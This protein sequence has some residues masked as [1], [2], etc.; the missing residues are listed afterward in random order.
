MNMVE[1]DRIHDLHLDGTLP[2]LVSVLLCLSDHEVIVV[3]ML[4]LTC[5]PAKFPLVVEAVVHNSTLPSA[6]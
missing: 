1:G 4:L 3:L 6:P 5:G 2:C